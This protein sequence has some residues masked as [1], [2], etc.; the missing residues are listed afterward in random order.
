MGSPTWPGPDLPAETVSWYDAVA[1]T[2]WL[3]A[4]LR[5]AGELE[6]GTEIR[7]PTEEE[8]EKAARGTD[9]REYPWGRGYHAGYANIDEK[10]VNA[11]PA[12][13]ERTTPVGAYPEG[14]SPF[15]ALDMAG[16]VWEWTLTEFQSKVSTDLTN[17][18]PRVVRGGSWGVPDG[19]RASLRDNFSPDNRVYYIGFRVV[20]AAPVQ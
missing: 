6:D 8:W 17:D 2:R 11:G 14:A 13:L 19:A 3:T 18:R 20:V 15:G 12:H 9:G 10:D 1:F 7:L 16:N 4:R 5:A